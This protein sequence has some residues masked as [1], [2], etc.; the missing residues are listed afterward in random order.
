MAPFLAPRAAPAA[1]SDPA[2]VRPRTAGYLLVA[3]AAVLGA[4]IVTVGAQEKPGR[5]SES[6]TRDVYASVL[7]NK[8][9]PVAGLGAADFV[10]KEDGVAREVLKAGPA[11]GALAVAVTVDD[12]QASTPFMQFIR[13]GLSDF[14]KKLDGKAQIALSTFGERPTPLVE[15]TDNAAALQKGV[16][17][18]FAKNGAGSY[19]LEA[20]VELS[21]GLE[22]RETARK[23]IVAIIIENG[24]EFSNL[25]YARVL[26]DLKRS[27]ATLHVLAVGAPAGNDSD[28]LRNRN[29]VMAEG[30][31]LTGGRRDQILAESG[32][33]ER[34]VQLADELT[35]QYV[36][37]YA[38]SDKLI[39]PEKLDVSVSK[40]GIVV[41]APKR[42]PGK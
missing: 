34:L 6:R 28:E 27:G 42:L 41:R 2:G 5:A 22:R 29:T 33:D 7:D 25:Y 18:L 15:Y 23:A 35:N 10:V 38:R 24:P 14:I 36:I 31:S 8:G 20:M 4:T 17:R 11:T 12:S 37:T 13:D 39:P 9:R 26:E 21:R 1:G 19:F 32:I 16:T 40:P 30:T 3:A